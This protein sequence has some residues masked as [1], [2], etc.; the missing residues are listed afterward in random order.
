MAIIKEIT[1]NVSGDSA[2]ISKPIYLYLG[3]GET[4]LLITIKEYSAVIGNFDDTNTNIIIQQ[5]SIYGQVCLLKP[6]NELVYSNRCEIIDDKLKFVIS[7]DF[8]D[9]IGEKGTHLMQIHLYDGLDEDANRLTIPPI[10]LTL[11]QPIC[12]SDDGG[13]PSN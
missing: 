6:N 7:K 11:L 4:T 1:V 3:D 5:E 12:M 10:S 8:I 2:K 13:K 9:Q